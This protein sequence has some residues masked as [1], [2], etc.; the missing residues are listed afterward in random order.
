MGRRTYNCSATG[1][2]TFILITEVGVTDLG[3]MLISTRG[4]SCEIEMTEF[5][6]AGGRLVGTFFADLETENGAIATITNG[7]I[8]VYRAIAA[9]AGGQEA[10]SAGSRRAA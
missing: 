7:F 5:G 10:V 2:G 8:D 6:N 3:D 1:A 4:E 9:S